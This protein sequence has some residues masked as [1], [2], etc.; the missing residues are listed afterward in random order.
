LANTI[1]F[2]SFDVGSVPH[3]E[4]RGL[5]DHF[6]G[7]GQQR[8]RHG[9]AE[10]L[11]SLHIAAWMSTLIGAGLVF[12]RRCVDARVRSSATEASGPMAARCSLLLQQRTNTST[13]GM[14]AKCQEATHALQQFPA[15]IGGHGTEPNEQ[16]TQQSPGLGLS[17][18]PQLLQL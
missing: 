10:R 4:H 14:V 2:R 9:E 8:R 12:D 16:K 7:A 3:T 11:G 1:T 18:S 17:R 15:C 5:F 13:A 6:I